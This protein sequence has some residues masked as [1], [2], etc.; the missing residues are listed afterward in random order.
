MS[1]TGPQVGTSAT[2]ALLIGGAAAAAGGLVL[3]SPALMGYSV[4]PPCPFR[5]LTGFDCPFCG[6]T[7]ATRELVT[8]D[9]SGAL[10]Y[11]VMVPILAL[12]AIGVGVWWLVSRQ[13][14]AVSFDPARGLITRKAVWIPLTVALLAFWLLRN[15]PAFSYLNSGG[16][17][18]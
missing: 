8:G 18:T 2:R 14:S 10:D 11:N 12:V 1:G 3:L 7:R 6:G 13:T 5:S 9:V 16:F 17:G 15:L 4:I